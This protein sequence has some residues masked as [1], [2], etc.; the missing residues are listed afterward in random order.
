MQDWSGGRYAF[1]YQIG[2]VI[3]HTSIDASIAIGYHR[4]RKGVVL[5]IVFEDDGFGY[6]GGIA[7]DIAIWVDLDDGNGNTERHRE[8]NLNELQFLERKA[9]WHGD[10]SILWVSQICNACSI[11]PSLPICNACS[12]HRIFVRSMS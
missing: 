2:D 7:A 6:D 4:Q 8:T 11:H 5:K 12:I 1:P 9:I 3:L 10:G